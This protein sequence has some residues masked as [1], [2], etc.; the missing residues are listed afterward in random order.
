MVE[1]DEIPMEPGVA[2]VC[3][4][5]AAT[6]RSFDDC[7]YDYACKWCGLQYDERDLIHR[8]ESI[9]DELERQRRVD[10]RERYNASTNR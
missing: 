6:L 9:I 2:K 10:N 5:C 7:E 1:Y 4:R 3:R 8:N